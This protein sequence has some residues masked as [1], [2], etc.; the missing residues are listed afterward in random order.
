MGETL[1]CKTTQTIKAVRSEFA[2]IANRWSTL[3]RVFLNPRFGRGAFKA[4]P[5]IETGDCSRWAGRFLAT[6]LD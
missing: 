3:S 4:G 1:I 2:A 6:L 5:E